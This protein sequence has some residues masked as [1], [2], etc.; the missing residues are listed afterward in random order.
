VTDRGTTQSLLI[1]RLVT[2]RLAGIVFLLIL[3]VFSDVPAFGVQPSASPKPASI[4]LTTVPAQ[5]QLTAAS[6]QEIDANVSRDLSSIADVTASL[7][8]LRNEIDARL[9]EDMK[10]LSASPFLDILYQLE[11]TWQGLNDDLSVLDRKLADGATNLDGERSRLNQL[12]E[13]WQATL[14]S[15]TQPDTPQSV[16]HRVQSTIDSVERARQTTESAHLQLLS[17]QGDLSEQQARVRTALFSI[18]QAQSQALKNLL[19]RDSPPIWSDQTNLASEWTHSQASFF[20]Q[21]QASIAFI[22]RYS[23]AFLALPL[24]VLAVAAAVQLM[25]RRMRKVTEQKP[26]LLHAASILDL[27]VSTALVLSLL[28]ILS[29]C[30]QAPRLLL[31]IV[32]ILLLAPIVLILR[33]LL[34]P[35]SYPILYALVTVALIGELRMLTV[36]ALPHSGRLLF[37]LQVLGGSCFFIW[38]LRYWRLPDSAAETLGRLWRRIRVI[39]K[40]GLIFMPA[41]FVANIFG[42]TQLGNLLGLLFLR[43]VFVAAILYTAIRIIE[44]LTAIALQVRPLSKLRLVDLHRPMLQ[45]RFFSLL[46]FCAFLLWATVTLNFVGLL[47]PLAAT[48]RSLLNASFAIGSLDISI[49]RI[50]TFVIAVW[51]SFVVSRFIRFLLEEDIYYHFRLAPGLPYAISTMLHYAILLLGFFIALGALGIDLT[52]ITILAG[53]F[54]VGVGFGLQTIIN[55]FV[56]GLIL[57]FERPIKIGDVIEVS[58]IVGEVRR[59]GIRASVIRTGDGSEVILPNGSLISGQVTNWTFSDV[60]RALQVSVNVADGVDPKRVIELLKSTAANYP[61]IVSQPPPQV[62]VDTF[63]S[64]TVTFQLR[65]WTDQHQTWTQLRSD[66]SLAVKEALALEKNATVLA[67]PRRR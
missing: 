60:L 41:A 18:E 22:K 48:V 45:R 61:G 6:L 5:A 47:A 4:P 27:P 42:Y 67:E 38:L 21:F 25:R 37:L 66:L 9:A 1:E 16:L 28:T 54:S 65:A 43:S 2:N 46:G 52:K 56:S 49:D 12:T 55:N 3:G 40:I 33:K 39:A 64:D 62:F 58:G 17:A 31:V 13:T 26:E 50:L 63:T 35:S 23:F 19:A 32:G 51:A 53:A 59:I 14:Q 57:L 36:A 34:L 20:A 30:P 29:I 10:L 8:G 7:S 44:G 15:A 24:L 11:S